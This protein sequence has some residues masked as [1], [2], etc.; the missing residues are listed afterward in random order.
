M[1][2]LKV[3]AAAGVALMLSTA[4]CSP[5]KTS[6]TE[7][8]GGNATPPAPAQGQ[9][10]ELRDAWSNFTGTTLGA[11][12]KAVNTGQEAVA[13]VG[14]RAP[15]L[16]DAT[17]HRSTLEHDMAKMQKVDKI[18][19]PAGS[20]VEFKPGDYHVMVQVPSDKRFKAGDEWDLVLVLQGGG[21]ITVKVPVKDAGG[22]TE[23]GGMKDD[24]HQDHMNGK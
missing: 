23:T 8:P 5:Q 17:L 9:G 4:G 10:I 18:D 14:A 7:T 15:G 24:G 20:T 19:L 6:P 12:M 11:Y 21:E 2:I 13:I 1:H 16:G 22:G 3:L